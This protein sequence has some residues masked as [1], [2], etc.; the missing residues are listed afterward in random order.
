MILVASIIV[1]HRKIVEHENFDVTLFIEPKYLL[2]PSCSQFTASKKHFV[3][4]MALGVIQYRT[5][6]FMFGVAVYSAEGIGLV[7]P[8]ETAMKES[9]KFPKV[10][11]L[12]TLFGGSLRCST[13]GAFQ[14]L[15]C[16][17]SLTCYN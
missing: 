12:L 15:F 11:S 4:E 16:S 6:L 10:C 5:F 9:E 17:W 8:C 14:V 1:V 13:T 3:Q 7:I 2:L